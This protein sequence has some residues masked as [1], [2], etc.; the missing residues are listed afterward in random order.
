MWELHLVNGP[1]G[2]NTAEENGDGINLDFLLVR[3]LLF[4]DSK[5]GLSGYN[6]LD[7]VKPEEICT[8]FGVVTVKERLH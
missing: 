5:Y 6:D 3:M 2:M 4:G 8:P 7:K 1:C